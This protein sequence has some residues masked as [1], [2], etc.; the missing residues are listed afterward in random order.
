MLQ[1][2][3]IGKPDIDLARAILFGKLQDFDGGHAFIS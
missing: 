2:G 1:A 3:D